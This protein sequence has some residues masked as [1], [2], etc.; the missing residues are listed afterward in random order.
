MAVR[1]APGR[2]PSTHLVSGTG[3]LGELNMPDELPVAAVD[4]SLT[5]TEDPAM[6]AMLV[7]LEARY[8][9]KG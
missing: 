5:Q 3:N 1:V 8:A 4:L 7:Q 9:N 2:S 6:A